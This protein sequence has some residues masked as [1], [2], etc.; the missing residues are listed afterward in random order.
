MSII[1][2]DVH[3]RYQ[4]IAML[5]VETGEIVKRRLEHENGEARLSTRVWRSRR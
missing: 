2:C 3:S 5:E 1:G 4:V